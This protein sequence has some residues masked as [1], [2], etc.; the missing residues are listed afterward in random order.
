M[1]DTNNTTPF[2]SDSSGKRNK[3]SPFKA[4]PIPGVLSGYFLSEKALKGLSGDVIS[5]FTELVSVLPLRGRI[6]APDL[7]ASLFGIKFSKSDMM[8]SAISNLSFFW[9]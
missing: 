6:K 5:V 8:A 2:L 3:P 9:H 4:S 1:N 7:L